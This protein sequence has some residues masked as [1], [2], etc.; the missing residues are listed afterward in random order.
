VALTIVIPAAEQLLGLLSSK[1]TALVIIR[2][3]ELQF[4]LAPVLAFIISLMAMLCGV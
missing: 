3:M 2:G 1:Q 4:L